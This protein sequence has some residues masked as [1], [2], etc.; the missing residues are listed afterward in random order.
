MRWAKPEEMT[1]PKPIRQSH[2]MKKVPR[3]IRRMNGPKR[4]RTFTTHKRIH[5]H[6]LPNHKGVNTHTRS[7]LLCEGVQHPGNTS[8]SRQV[9]HIHAPRRPDHKSLLTNKDRKI[10]R[11]IDRNTRQEKE[12]NQSRKGDAGGGFFC[13]AL[14]DLVP[15]VAPETPQDPERFAI[16]EA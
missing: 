3:Q 13:C 5:T 6:A 16:V 11:Y 15:L 10:E 1:N 7:R 12:T 4:T 14:P 8:Q 9:Q 2:F